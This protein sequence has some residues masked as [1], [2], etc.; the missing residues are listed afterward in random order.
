MFYRLPQ[1]ALKELEIAVQR[2]AK[3]RGAEVTTNDFTMVAGHFATT[4][5]IPQT[6]ANSVSMTV[7]PCRTPL[8]FTVTS[9]PIT[10]GSGVSA[11]LRIAS[12]DVPPVL[13]LAP[14][15]SVSFDSS[16]SPRS[17][18]L[19]NDSSVIQSI[20]KVPQAVYAS[21]AARDIEVSSK[22][23]A[24]CPVLPFSVADPKKPSATPTTVSSTARP[25]PTPML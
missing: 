22:P 21:F 2:E 9:P 6:P 10:D 11:T 18:N 13:L 19:A 23:H 20:L 7:K 24:V 3:Q 1:D 17:K 5:G 16:A 14:S 15:Q 4:T 12:M 25:T 8:P